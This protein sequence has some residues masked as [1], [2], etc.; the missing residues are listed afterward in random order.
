MPAASIQGLH[1]ANSHCCLHP[2]PKPA[3]PPWGHS[4]LPPCRLLEQTVTSAYSLSLQLASYCL[5]RR[6]DHLCSCCCHL[7]SLP[8]SPSLP[9]P[10][11]VVTGNKLR[12]GQCV[13]RSCPPSGRSKGSFLSS[14]LV[15]F[16][17]LLA[18]PP[19]PTDHLSGSSGASAPPLLLSLCPCTSIPNYATSLASIPTL[20]AARGPS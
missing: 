11:T 9:F 7:F 14:L 17:S 5:Q 13:L 20:E 10:V 6:T 18:A 1:G 3:P 2:K 19:P 12:R 15:I 4:T 16:N 8:P